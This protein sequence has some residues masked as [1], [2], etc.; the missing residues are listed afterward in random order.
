MTNSYA[1]FE[2][3]VQKAGFIRCKNNFT[4]Y[5]YYYRSE[6]VNADHSVSFCAGRR[7]VLSRID[8]RPSSRE[9]ARRPGS[10]YQ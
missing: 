9:I 7:Y 4:V 2:R 10:I 6:N 1:F 5:V 3:T 8:F